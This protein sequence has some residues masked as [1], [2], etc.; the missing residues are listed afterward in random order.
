MNSL[1]LCLSSSLRGNASKLYLPGF[2]NFDS[3]HLNLYKS[4]PEDIKKVLEDIFQHSWSVEV[5]PPCHEYLSLT[6]VP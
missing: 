4:L 2:D 3:W 1:L 5:P 6:A